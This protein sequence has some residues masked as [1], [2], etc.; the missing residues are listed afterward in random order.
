MMHKNIII[1]LAILFALTLVNYAGIIY[2]FYGSNN[3]QSALNIIAKETQDL[4][5]AIN[6]VRTVT[7]TAYSPRDEYYNPDPGHTASM[8]YPKIGTVAV[9]RDLFQQG[10]VFGRQIYIEG[11]G[12]YTIQDLMNARWENRIDIVLGSS[13]AAIQFGKKLDVTVALLTI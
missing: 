9:S 2:Q 1:S 4:K 12:V 13:K 3:I 10:W 7:L 11:H 6:P 8:R 5:A